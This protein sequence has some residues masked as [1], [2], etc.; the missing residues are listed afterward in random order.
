MMRFA[1]PWM[2][3]LL[4]AVVGDAVWRWPRRR[5]LPAARIGFPAI[6]L[7]DGSEPAGRARWTWVPPVLRSLGLACCVVALARP[8]T[9]GEVRDTRLSGRNI[10]LALDISSSMKAPD[11][12]AGS[13]VAVAKQELAEF[14]ARRP[15]DFMGLVLFAG[16]AFTQAPLTNDGAVVL[17]LLRRADIGMLPDGTAIGTALA[18]SEVHLKDLPRGTGV[19]VVLTDGGNNAGRPDPLTAAAAARALGIHIYTI[20]VSGNARTAT[21]LYKTGIPANMETPDAITSVEEKLLT[22]IATISG[23]RYFRATDDAALRGIMADIDRLEQ[24]EVHLTE[25]LS[26]HEYFWV[27]LLVGLVLIGTAG[28]LRLTALRTLP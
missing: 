10:V 25:V 17:D 5:R 7:V 14:I 4:I 16:R 12:K 19:I 28:V 26:Y 9:D 22:R 18:M 23:G 20:G 13:R 3:V 8:R 11:F 6:G 2:F 24:S 21:A 27:P 15:H 1:D